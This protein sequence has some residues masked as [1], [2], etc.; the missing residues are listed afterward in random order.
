[1]P[2]PGASRRTT[3]SC[4]TCTGSARRGSA[5]GSG[6]SWRPPCRGSGVSDHAHGRLTPVM[7]TRADVDRD[8]SGLELIAKTT[9]VLDTLERHGESSAQ[10]IALATGEPVSS[11]YR[12]LQSLVAIG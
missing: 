1:M 7:V 4:W 2:T 5:N 3:T 6:L 10:Q 8:S 9:S 12:L 11:I